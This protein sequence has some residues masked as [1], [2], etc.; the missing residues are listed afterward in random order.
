MI[1]LS[2]RASLGLL[3]AVL[4]WTFLFYFPGLSGGFLFDD[5]NE[6]V[7]NPNIQLDRLSLAGLADAWSG[8]IFGLSGRSLP[9]VSLAIDHS[10][11]GLN[12]FGYKLTN[13]L[14]HLINT[15]GLFWLANRMLALDATVRKR[16]ALRALA[17]FL[18]LLWAIHP[19]QIST[20][21]YVVQRMEMM[22]A[23]FIILGLVAYVVGRQRQVAGHRGGWATL[24]AVPV[25]MALSL[26]CKETGLLL[27]GY[28]FILE[29]SFFRFRAQGQRDTAVI[30]GIWV[31]AALAAIAVYAFHFWPKYT[32]ELAYA[33]RDF[34]LWERL[35][36]QLRALPLYLGQILWP[37]PEHYHFYYDSFAASRSLLEPPTTLL[38]G[39][40]LAGLAGTAIVV[41]R[42]MPLFFFGVLWFF[43]SHALTSNIASLE[44][45]FEHRNYLAIFGV[46]LAAA[47]IVR[48][49][50]GRLSRGFLVTGGITLVGFLSFLTLL[51]TATWG[52][53]LELALGFKKRNPNSERANFTVGTIYQRMSDRSSQSPFFAMA[54]AAFEKAG[55]IP[56]STPLPEHALIAMY[57][58]ADREPEAEWWQRLID[59][60]EE[61]PRGPMQIRAVR[62]LLEIHN[63]GHPVDP[64]RL[65]DAG[66]ALLNK[67]GLNPSVNYEFA[68]LALE[69]LGD[70]ALARAILDAGA[71]RSGD[72]EWALRVRDVLIRQGHADFAQQWW[73][74]R[75]G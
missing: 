31:V 1:S 39:L 42:R 17:L 3:L 19:L 18:V 33:G 32:G 52:N 51:T 12:P 23:T 49:L 2:P 70:E 9:M 16:G 50:S 72:P 48:W 59:K 75:S 69:S 67:P 14:I 58:Y 66:I 47:D 43:V 61:G 45:V 55:Q 8:F 62:K 63:E 24:S 64:D 22:A 73:Q 34:T 40:L 44:L 28:A 13:V 53:P 54:E 11:W 5:F 71:A 15:A 26:L 25:C 60:V 7:N 74:S 36:S 56:G 35:L 6:I 4:A 57:A 10:F 20:V 27:P 29:L 21:L 46:L 68:L 30:R 65:M 38:G 41:R 37:D